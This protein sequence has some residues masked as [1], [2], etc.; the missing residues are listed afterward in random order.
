MPFTQNFYASIGTVNNVENL[1]GTLTINGRNVLSKTS[2]GNDLAKQLSELTA[3]IQGLPG[4]SSETKTKAA[5]EIKAAE[6]EAKS[7]KPKGHT[8]K[9]HLD[10]A[11]E[12][13]KGA[14][15]AASN[16]LSLGRV[17]LEIGKWA[18]AIFV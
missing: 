1:N 15:D 16:A 9:E 11:S 6:E 18:I 8:I 10:T 2:D 17:L 14:T 7:E 12:T 4:V 13:L 5:T 3:A